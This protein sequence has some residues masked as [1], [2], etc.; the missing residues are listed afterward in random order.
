MK[1]RMDLI[2]IRKV[3]I[4]VPHWFKHLQGKCKDRIHSKT[5]LKKNIQ[6]L[7]LQ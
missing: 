1:A 6:V 7:G 3:C 2:V 5:L 4:I